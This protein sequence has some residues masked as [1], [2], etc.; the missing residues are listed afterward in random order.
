M[1]ASDYVPIFFKYRL[2]LAG[3]PPHHKHEGMSVL[4]RREQTWSENTVYV[5][6]WTHSRYWR[7]LRV[8]GFE[9]F[10]THISKIPCDAESWIAALE[11]D[12]IGMNRHRALD[13]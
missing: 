4:G 8:T 2:H 11:R 1:A 3:R 6:F 13:S 12:G 5:A 9:R 7:T 10:L